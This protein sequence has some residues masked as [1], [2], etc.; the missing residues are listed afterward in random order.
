MADDNGFDVTVV[1]PERVLVTGTASQVVLR[2]ADGDI[3]F[4]VGHTPLVGAVEPGVI[5]VVREDGEEE[6]I[7]VHGGFVQVELGTDTAEESPAPSSGAGSG[8]GSSARSGVGAGSRARGTRVTILAGV[9]ELA[10]EIDSERARAALDAAEARIAERG[11]SSGRSGA[12]S[13][14][15]GSPGSGDGDEVDAELVE[16]E[17]ALRRAQVRLEAAGTP[18]TATA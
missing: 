10:G 11:S 1:A 4:L 6:R 14:G 2:T 18:A 8:A 3:T 17:G 15:A 5:R 13:S 12:G 7:A 16:A 9:A